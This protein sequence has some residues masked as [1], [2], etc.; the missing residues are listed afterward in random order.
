MG[1]IF[2]YLFRRFI[3]SLIDSA[4][5]RL[6]QDEY[7][8]NLAELLTTAQKVSPRVLLE[9]VLRAEKGRPLTR[10]FGSPV[11]LSAW[12]KILLNPVQ[13]FHL[14]T[15]EGIKIDT[16]VTIGPLAKRPLRLEIPLLIAGMSYGGALSLR[17][18]VALAKAATQTGTATNTGE[19]P[20]IKEEREAARFLIGQYNRGGWLKEDEDLAQLDAIEIQVGQGAQGSAPMVTKATNIDADFRRAFDLG[21]D[22]DAVI[23]ARLPGV[24]KP[25]DLQRLIARLRRDFEVPVGVKLAS[26]HHL[27]KEL[28]FLLEE[29]VDFITIDGAEGGT[30]G[31]PTTLQDDLGLPTLPALIRAANFLEK[32]GLKRKTTLII[33]GGLTTP[34]HFLKALALGADAF[35]VGTVAILAL[36]HRQAIRALP[37]EPPTSLV[38]YSGKRKL[39]L[40]EQRATQSLVNFINSCRQEME[41]AVISLGKTSFHSLDRQDLVTMDRD[42][43]AAAGID[44]G[45]Y[46]PERQ[47]EIFQAGVAHWRSIRQEELRSLEPTPAEPASGENGPTH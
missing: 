39:D 35:Y 45:Y 44:Y 9:T 37:W 3:D 7:T 30:H 41:Q 32:K 23:H 22:E 28:S 6:V 33:T 20:L 46:P 24:E 29:E 18:K 15:D 16:S 31:G 38:L 43:A 42:I 1:P 26:S 4:V 17:A 14:P 40:D 5:A 19:A 8:E 34:G 13:T 47:R 27:E 10:P 2:D 12:E 36:I 21:N 11:I 25:R